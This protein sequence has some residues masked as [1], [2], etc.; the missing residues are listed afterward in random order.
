M[1]LKGIWELSRVKCGRSSGATE[2][3]VLRKIK[4]LIVLSSALKLISPAFL[5]LRRKQK[6]LCGKNE[7]QHKTDGIINYQLLSFK[8]FKLTEGLHKLLGVGLGLFWCENCSCVLSAQ[9]SP[10]VSLWVFRFTPFL[11]NQMS[12]FQFDLESVFN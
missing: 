5:K 8:I 10:E 3:H 4:K 7:R 11:K 1:C 12:K 9:T 6:I 2:E